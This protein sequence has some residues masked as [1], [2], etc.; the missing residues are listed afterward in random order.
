M[1]SKQVKVKCNTLEERNIK[2]LSRIRICSQCRERN[3]TAQRKE[4]VFIKGKK[5]KEGTENMYVPEISRR[6]IVKPETSA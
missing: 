6:E 2:E 5:K 1:V 3:K 4:E